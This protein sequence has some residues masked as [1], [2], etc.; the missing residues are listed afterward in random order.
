MILSSLLD[1]YF[2]KITCTPTFIA[3][4]FTVTKTWKQP[5][6]PLPEEKRRSSTCIQW[7]I[8]QP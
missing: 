3:A 8:I 2:K 5:K 7:S 4:L 6:C 1:I